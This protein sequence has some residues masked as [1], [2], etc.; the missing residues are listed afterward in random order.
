MAG[1]LKAVL[2]LF[3]ILAALIASKDG[4]APMYVERTSLIHG[5]AD[6]ILPRSVAP[7]S[8]LPGQALQSI[9]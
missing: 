1:L 5:F 6:K 9:F 2:Q 7:A 4:T 3:P 8:K